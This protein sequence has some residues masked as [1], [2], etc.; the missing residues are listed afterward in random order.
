[1]GF[2]PPEIRESAH[3]AVPFTAGWQEP[4]IVLPAEWRA[5]DEFRLRAV[6]AHEMAHV[7]RRDWLVSLL[8]AINRGVFWINPVA[9]FIERR[10]AS[11]AEECC[12]AA[13]IGAGGDARRYAGVVLDFA[14]AAVGAPLPATAM[15]RSSRVGARI[16]RLLERGT[17][18]PRPVSGAIWGLMLGIALPVL[19]AAGAMT[20]EQEKTGPVVQYQPSQDLRGTPIPGATLTAVQALGL[21]AR[22]QKNLHDLDARAQL[23]GY[24][25]TNALFDRWTVHV[26]WLVENHPESNV[27]DTYPMG[28]ASYRGSLVDSATFEK[29]RSLWQRKAAENPASV[30]VL[31]HAARFLSSSDRELAQ[32]LLNDARTANP[33]DSR[34]LAQLVHSY[35][36]YLRGLTGSAPEAMR[37]EGKRVMELLESSRDAELVGSVGL[38]N[39][40]SGVVIGEL[41]PETKARIEESNRAMNEIANRLLERAVM[42]EP[43]NPKW[44]QA[45]ADARTGR[46]LEPMRFTA[47]PPPGPLSRI[48]VGSNVQQAMLLSKPDP[49]YPAL[50]RQARISG[51]VRFTVII[52]KEGDVSQVTLVAGHPLL[53]QAASNAVKQ[54]RYKPTLLNG[55]PVEVVTQLTFHLR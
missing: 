26:L 39:R 52:G 25:F 42:L 21:E 15:A 43:G 45:L 34:A 9:W 47:T 4:A 2:P 14:A 22:V 38:E 5:W 19:Y 46:G 12:D 35:S 48:T 31:L 44:T 40:R 41:T 30:E 17:S 54:Y 10:L 6:L 27:H 23:V 37:T 51:T 18:A 28:A 16:E 53:V 8:A 33:D 49:E 1:M 13:A 24:Y 3:V 29:L 20:P 55:Q 50:A 7:Q 11:L 36:F 32:R